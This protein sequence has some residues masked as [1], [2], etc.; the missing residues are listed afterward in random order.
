MPTNDHYEALEI[1]PDADQDAVKAA[2][3]ALALMFHPDRNPPG[4]S[5][6]PPSG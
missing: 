4:S 6:R 1:T 3:R 2:Y 5:T